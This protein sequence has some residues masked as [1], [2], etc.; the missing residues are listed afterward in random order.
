LQLVLLTM[1]SVYNSCLSHEIKVIIESFQ[2]YNEEMNKAILDTFE[3][4]SDIFK[5]IIAVY[6][7]DDC[8][9]QVSLCKL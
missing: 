3:S 4:I 8:L 2:Y 7:M 9:R 1:N 6:F 5:E